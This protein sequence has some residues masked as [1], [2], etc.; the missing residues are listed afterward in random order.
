MF[1]LEL[2]AKRAN[3]VRREEYWAQPAIS[4]SKSSQTAQELSL[5]GAAK[6]IRG[7]LIMKQLGIWGF[8]TGDA[9]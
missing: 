7:L 3:K 6:K 2:M 5:K 8:L 9:G 1:C 4:T